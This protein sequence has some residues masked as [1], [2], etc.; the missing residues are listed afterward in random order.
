MGLNSKSPES[1]ASFGF[2]VLFPLAFV[3]NAMVP[4]ASHAGM[5]A[6]A[7]ELEPGE[8]GVRRSTDL[9][10][11]PNPA[12]GVHVWP[13]QHPVEASLIWSAVILA[14]AAPLAGH[15]SLPTAH[16]RVSAIIRALVGR[17]RARGRLTSVSEGSTN[18][19][20][21]GRDPH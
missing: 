1:A 17:C 18:G 19:G 8:R 6:G 12:G 11:N 14:I 15:S 9:W 16:H 5:A 13:M 7:R 3:S 2:I 10:Q 20:D 21:P 4:T